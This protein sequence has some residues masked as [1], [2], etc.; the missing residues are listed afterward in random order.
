MKG[1]SWTQVEAIDT[2]NVVENRAR[3]VSCRQALGDDRKG[4]REGGC[5]DEHSR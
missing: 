4:G 3:L 1:G 5:W 2:G